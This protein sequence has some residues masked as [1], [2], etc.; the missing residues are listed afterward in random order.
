M[1]SSV[2][3]ALRERTTGTNL[4]RKGHRSPHIFLLEVGIQDQ[5]ASM[6]AL[7]ADYIKSF[8]ASCISNKLPTAPRHRFIVHQFSDYKVE[9]SRLT[10]PRRPLFSGR[11]K[12]AFYTSRENPNARCSELQATPNPPWV[13]CLFYDRPQELP[14]RRPGPSAG[15]RHREQQHQL[16][17]PLVTSEQPPLRL[18]WSWRNPQLRRTLCQNGL[19]S[20]KARQD[21]SSPISNTVSSRQ[22]SA[23]LMS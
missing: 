20:L 19:R 18:Q 14:D 13:P 11:V 2:W 3:H 6:V 1:C 9:G 7:L 5:S 17:L 21:T 16:D 22:R 4:R 15:P 23:H 10:V 8:H 12:K